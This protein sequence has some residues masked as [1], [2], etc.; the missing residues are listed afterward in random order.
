MRILDSAKKRYAT[1]AFDPNK[2]L[3]QEQIDMLKQVLR[4]SP[5]SINIQ[6]WHFMLISSDEAK[7]KLAEACLGP[8]TYNAEKVKDAPLVIAL[9][10]SNEVTGKDVQRVIDQ[11]F[12]DGR[13]PTETAK[14]ERTEMLI[15][16]VNRRNQDSQVARAWVDKQT[17][18]AL[19]QVLLAAADLGIDSVPIEG[20]NADVVNENF[21]LT[22]KGYHVTVLAAFGYHSEAD[23][24]AKL[25]KSRLPEEELFSE[26]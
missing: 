11:E 19:G 7:A 21:A 26:Y 20:F 18:I 15:N 1:K 6:A 22:D 16:N 14:N 5:S 10:A 24:N 9:C 17:Y 13:F 8:M 3:S 12:E 2:K 25:P 4:L 23:F